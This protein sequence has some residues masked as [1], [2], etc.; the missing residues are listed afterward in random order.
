MC[1]IAGIVDLCGERRF[2]RPILERMAQ[3][4]AH[5]GPDEEGFFEAPGI[6]LA[7]RRLSIVGL[8]DGQQPLFNEDGSVVVVFNGE[9]FDYVEQRALLEAKGHR[10]STHADTEVLVHL[11]EEYG[12][13]MVDRLD[14]Q[15]AVALYDLRRRTLLLARDRVGIAPLHWA[16]RGNTLYFGS[17]IKAIL[18]S[19]EVAPE[20][21]PQGIDH[22]FTFFAM[23]TRRTAFKGIQAVHPAS[24]LKVQLPR[25]GAVGS[26]AERRYWDLKFPDRGEE[27]DSRDGRDLEE[28]FAAVFRRAVEI[29]L[30][31]DVPVVGYLSGGVDSTTVMLTASEAKGEPIPAFTIQIP[32]QGLDE[33]DRA[34]LAAGRI[35]SRPTLVKCDS[36]AIA[37]AYPQLI[38][39]AEAPVMDTACSAL[40]CLAREVR[41]QGYKVALTGEG[42]DDWL[43][44]YPWFKAGKALGLLDRGGFSPGNW[45][46]RLALKYNSPRA[47]WSDFACLQERLGGP[48]GVADLYGMVSLTRPRFYSQSMWSDLGGASAW[49]DLDINLAGLRRW[50][51]LNRALYLGY[52]TMLSGLLMN[53]KGD[54]PAMRNSV[55]TRYPFLDLNVIDFCASL[56]PRWKLR[57]LW[58]DKHLLRNYAA[59]I[60]PACIANRPK[61]MFRA[62]FAN[63]FFSKPPPF[64]EQLINEESLRKTGYFE[65]QQVWHFRDI[66]NHYRALSPGKKLVAEMGL[67]GV[68]ATQLWHHTFLGG[69]LC[70]LPTWN[71]AAE[72]PI[73]SQ[74]RPRQPL[75]WA[76]ATRAPGRTVE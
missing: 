12:E 5:R 32:A 53:H 27:R 54:R 66:Y 21:D 11:W 64:V 10:F 43:A 7:S 19:G 49:D 60:L 2:P 4:I 33:T 29:R 20:A 24:Y 59:K 51:P 15:Y 57:G 6:S 68:M 14:G 23:G 16:R 35:G 13:Q 76:G 3:A 52:K 44:G 26:I 22:V 70:D 1:G 65:P 36:D 45:L 28:E 61:A 37:T 72:H 34:L 48:N 62:P 8:A 73:L 17:E 50:H 47:R 74:T 42:A 38:L 67:T 69:G 63:T 55:E 31:A 71:A 56:H 46:R 30:R 41:R 40:Y 18:A 58:R 39:A 25:S 75:A 9:I